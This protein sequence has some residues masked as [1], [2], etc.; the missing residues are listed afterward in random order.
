MASITIMLIIL[1]SL[2][3]ILAFSQPS[4]MEQ[5]QFNAFKVFHRNQYYRLISHALVHANWEHLLVNMIVLFSFGK[6][7]EHY[8]AINFGANGRF[9]YLALFI[10]SIIFSSLAS[11]VKQRNNVYYNAVGASGATSAILFAA[12]FFDPWAKI[13]FF[14]ILPMPGIIFGALYLYYSYYMSRKN[15]DNIGHDA[16]FL[17]A[18]FGFFAPVFLRPTLLNDFLSLLMNFK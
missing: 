7:V 4:V 16:H 10:L 18:V 12:I 2:V 3:S 11:L 5:F 6:A 14:G 13:Y 9:Y 15:I 17:G 1:I 8:F